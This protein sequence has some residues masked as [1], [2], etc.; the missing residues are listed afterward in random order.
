LAAP[1]SRMRSRPPCCSSPARI[2][3]IWAGRCC[4]RTAARSLGD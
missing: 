1:V 3:P 4:T 2:H